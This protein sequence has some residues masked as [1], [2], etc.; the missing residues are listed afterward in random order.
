MYNTQK[1]SDRLATNA[2]VFKV[3]LTILGHC[4]LNS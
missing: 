2:V 1:Q 4:V 3:Y